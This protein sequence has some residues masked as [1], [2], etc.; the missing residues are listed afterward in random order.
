MFV[1]LIANVTCP[2]LTLATASS[3]SAIL[4]SKDAS[5]LYITHADKPCGIVFVGITIT[6]TSSSKIVAVCWAVI[7]IL[8]LFGKMITFLAFTSLTAA[9]ISSVDGFIVCPPLTT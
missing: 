9:T 1:S 4:S 8:E 3:I 2:V 6:F 7:T 5:G